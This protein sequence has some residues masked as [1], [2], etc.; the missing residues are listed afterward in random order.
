MNR[1]PFGSMIFS[2]ERTVVHASAD[3]KCDAGERGNRRE[4]GRARRPGDQRD[5]VRIV[6]GPDREKTE[7]G[8]RCR[9]DGQLRDRDR[10]G[11]LPARDQ[12]ERPD[13]GG[14]AGRVHRGAA[15]R[16]I[17]GD[18]FP[19]GGGSP[20]GRPRGGGADGRA[21]AAAAGDAG[22][23]HPGGGAGDGAA[24]AVPEL[25]VG[26][27][28]TRLPGRG[29][30]SVAVSPGRLRQCPARRRDDGHPD[31]G[32]G[33]RRVPVVAVRAVLRRGGP[34]GRADG[35]RL[36]GA[37]QRRRGHLPGGGGRGDGADPARPLSRGPGEAQV[38]RGA[39]GAAVPWR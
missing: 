39:E 9:R 13:L 34:G 6:R 35:L 25:A 22:P 8:R 31:L 38:G 11:Q 28:G 24:A 33:G 26:L 18:G 7:Q 20:G 17:R 10:A 1:G 37:R 21:T 29:L 30:G 23:G 14:R 4:C 5:D 19:P 2:S 16:G 12:R 32:R 27:A 36:A 15:P 3:G